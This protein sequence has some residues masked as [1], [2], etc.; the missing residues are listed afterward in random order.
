MGERGTPRRADGRGHRDDGPVTT[1]AGAGDRL[2][3]DGRRCLWHRHR[4]GGRRP[5]RHRSGHARSGHLRQ[6]RSRDGRHRCAH[7]CTE[8]RVEGHS[9]RRSPAADQRARDRVPGQP[10]HAP[11]GRGGDGLEGRGDGG[12]S[13]ERP[14]AR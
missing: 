7:G 12:P 10:F 3:T 11:R 13:V 8:D 2:R 9:H 4:R 5:W 14:G 1:R 6:P